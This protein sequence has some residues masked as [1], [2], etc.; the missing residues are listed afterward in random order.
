MSYL[1][2]LGIV[3]T[4]A[5]ALAS[6]L[7]IFFAVYAKHNGR[8][9]RE[10]LS[11]VIAEGNERLER[12]LKEFREMGQEGNKELGQMV[13]QGNKDLGQMIQ[14]GN[15][16]LRRMAQEGNKE[17]GRMIQEGNKMIV[18]VLDRMDERAEARNK[19]LV[20][21]LHSTQSS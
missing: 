16:E 9:T 6:V 11:R 13:Q 15:K 4:G 3:L 21:I 2:I 14:D 8:M 17:L 18:Q 1:E 10:H 19:E 5:G 7:G 12:I 20:S